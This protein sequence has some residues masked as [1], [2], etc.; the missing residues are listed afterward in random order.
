MNRIACIGLALA[1]ACAPAIARQNGAESTVHDRGSST[2]IPLEV[3][4][5]VPLRVALE[6]DLRVRKQGQTVHGKVVQ[7]V[8]SFNKLVIPA[9]TEV[10]GHVDR[11]ENVPN[12]RRTL[13]A[14]NGEFTPNHRV[15]IKFD[16]LVLADGRHVPLQTVVTPGTQGT[17]QFVTPVRE[18][19]QNAAEK[20]AS[21]K[22]TA[23]R[24]EI[25]HDW[26][27][28]RAQIQTPGK[29]H[30]LEKYAVAQ[31]PVHPQYFDQGA[32]FNAELQAP[33]NFGT[34]TFAPGALSS[35][36][37]PPP[38]D[39][40]VHALLNSELSSA[41]AKKGD[42][43]HAVITDP[44][45]AGDKLIF[46][47]GSS[48]DGIVTQAR[49]A[50][51]F[52]RN[53]QLRIEFRQIAPPEGTQQN[54]IANL[55]GVEVGGGEHLALDEEGG[56]EVK[57]PK[58]RY[59]TTGIAV[60]LAVSSARPDYEHGTVDA[61]GDTQKNAASG[62]FGFRLIG[63]VTS[64]AVHSRIF[65]ASMSAYGAAF[66]ITTHFLLRGREVVYEKFTP[67]VIS[68]GARDKAQPAAA[69]S[70]PSPFEKQ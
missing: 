23:T 49:P 69:G 7:S 35:I 32:V 18:R 64:A 22:V 24:E 10:T 56:A 68:L 29:M 67:M 42:A 5:G 57:T 66:A 45:M 16:E 52:H 37:A 25:R 36:A 20:T 40:V 15:S 4:S 58:T 2:T 26:E 70:R 44:V 8:Y 1:A 21:A 61:A 17:L 62:A 53:G 30:R 51:K 63:I 9:G 11:I 39:T 47:A 38:P 50:R 27:T 14:L 12:G 6:E 28:A 41:T 33:L 59:L 3:A 34:Q 65:S 60:A 46:P 31:L 19:K 13:A 54:I 43:F 55:E 48:I